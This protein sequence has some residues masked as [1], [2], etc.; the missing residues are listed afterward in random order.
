MTAAAATDFFA[1]SVRERLFVPQPEARRSVG[2]ELELLPFFPETGLPCPLGVNGST[3]RSTLAFVRRYGATAGWLEQRSAKGTPYFKLPTGGMLTF[4]PGG[5]LELC[6]PPRQSISRLLGEVRATLGGLRRSAAESGIE[7]ESVGIDPRNDISAVPLQ[8]E[9][10]RYVRMTSYFDQIGPSGV[11]MMRQTA[12]T[13]VSLDGG[14]DPAFRWRLLCDLAPFLTAIFAN[15]SRYAGVDTGFASFRAQCWRLLDPTRTGVPDDQSS[16][17]EAYTRFALDAVD[18]WR[19][20]EDGLYRPFGEWVACGAWN[21]T[22]WDDHLSTLFPEVR[23]RGHLEVRS[24]DALGEDLLDA[25][26]V[27]LAG[28]VYN[29]EAAQESRRLLVPA[30]EELLNTAARCGLKDARIAEAAADLIELGLSGARALGEACVGGE[31]LDRAA[32]CFR[33]LT[34]Q[35]R[36]PDDPS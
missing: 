32:Q 11:R 26:V 31:E 21:E 35:H 30:D 10:E 19:S 33:D 4:E 22:Q 18:M 12:A 8:V 36:S 29:P 24:I 27:L 6:T 15:S 17:C 25:P 20:D 9:S 5:Q 7:L 23:P 1:R 16:A 2:L 13:Q 34:R 14:A 28:L 3:G